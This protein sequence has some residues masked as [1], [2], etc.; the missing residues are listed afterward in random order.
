MNFS[1]QL[2]LYRERESLSQEQLAEKIYVT[3]QTI[4]KWENEK[5][6]PDI[7]NLIALSTLFDITL[8]ELIK[9]DLVKMKHSVDV[10]KMNKWAWVM[11]IF[12]ALTIISIFPAFEL[13]GWY[14][15]GVSFIF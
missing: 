5:T 13:W 7:H 2:K 14:G 4:S 8:D 12:M 10:D 1:K 11:L 9:G 15:F 6:Y 3:K